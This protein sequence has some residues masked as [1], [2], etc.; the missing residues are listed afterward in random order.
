MNAESLMV[1]PRGVGYLVTKSVIGLST[2]YRMPPM[3]GPATLRAVGTVR[4]VPTEVPDPFGVVGQLT[5]TGA[6]I[7]PDGTALAIRTYSSAY[8]WPVRDGDVAGAL[9]S[10]PVRVSLPAQPQGESIAFAGDELLVASEHAGTPVYALARPGLGPA[11]PAVVPSSTGSTGPSGPSGP[12]G[13]TD[14]S[15]PDGG[16]AKHPGANGGTVLIVLMLVLIGGAG[17]LAANRRRLRRRGRG[18]REGAPGR[19]A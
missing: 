12:S 6:A 10:T 2:V 3:P 13:P 1:S 19:T 15:S 5:A 17:W 14:R 11:A 8:L 7:S 18:S 9:T 4:F 16:K